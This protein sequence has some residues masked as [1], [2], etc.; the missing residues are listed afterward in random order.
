MLKVIS[1]STFDLQAVLDTLVDLHARTVRGGHGS[2]QPTG[3]IIGVASYGL[4]P[5]LAAYM[6]KP[7]ADPCGPGGSIVG[8]NA[9]EGRPFHVHDVLA[10]PEYDLKSR[11]SRSA[12]FAPCWA[13]RSCA[14]ERRSASSP[15]Q[16]TDVRPF[17][18]KQIELV[19][20]F[21]DQA[22]IAIENVRLF[23]E[24]Q[25]RTRDLT[26]SLEQQTATVEVLEVISSS[27]TDTQPA[28]DA[29][30]ESGLKLF[31]SAR[32]FRS[33]RGL[34]ELAAMAG[35]APSGRCRSGAGALFRCPLTREYHAQRRILDRRDVDLADART[36]RIRLGRPNSPGRLPRGRR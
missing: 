18:D 31:R 7:S 27:P 20:T 22:V 34:V 36:R 13:S 5:E 4:P 14:K 15:L 11:P 21:A 26:E 28:F 2:Y 17:T 12:A 25:A 33:R 9:L 10:D 32:S 30:V 16:R 35:A 1:R 23:D 8:Q 3:R 24:V 19:E 6:A 29:I